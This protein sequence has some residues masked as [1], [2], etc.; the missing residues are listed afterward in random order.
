M[1]ALTLPGLEDGGLWQVRNRLDPAA[2]ALADR[3]YS[4][5]RPG[6]GQIGPPGR[7]LVLVTPCERAVWLTHWP[8]AH[9]ALDG[10]D[11]WRCSI[12]R[13]EEGAP[14]ASDLIRAAMDVTA[15]VW[16]D[17]PADGWCTWID[18]RKVRHKRDP[19]RCYLKAGWWV[20]RDWSH[21][22]LVRLR[23]ATQSAGGGP[24]AG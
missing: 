1:S 7:K 12:F 19:G 24:D 23:A 13:R 9:L 5:R 18:T 3:H 17:R 10:M 22:Y 6:S 11:F 2:N 15:R 20:D 21:R 14:L 4:R 8:Y 16:S